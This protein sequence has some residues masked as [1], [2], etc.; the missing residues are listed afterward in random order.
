MHLRAELIFCWSQIISYRFKAFTKIQNFM[1]LEPR[2]EN[3]QESPGENLEQQKEKMVAVVAATKEEKEEAVKLLMRRYEEAGYLSKE[4]LDSREKILV[5]L[6]SE[7]S[8]TFIVKDK[9]DKIVGTISVIFDTDKGLPMDEIFKDELDELRNHEGIKIAE[10]GRLATDDKYTKKDINMFLN[11][12]A[13]TLNYL[14]SEK[15][16]YGCIAI[17]PK[18]V[19]IYK[20][21]LFNQIGEEK[22]YGSLKDAPAV[23][24]IVNVKEAEEAMIKEGM[25]GVVRAL[26]VKFSDLDNC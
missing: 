22:K 12:F 26:V 10:I 16:D 7:S 6:E 14:I 3:V 23:A 5:S 15:V 21:L 11:L 4:K 19:A 24:M 18:Q 1:N 13:A 17:N 25:R 9:E 20:T 8:R 2:K